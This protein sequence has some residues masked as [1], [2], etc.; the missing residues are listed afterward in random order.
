MKIL[1]HP[2]LHK[3]GTTSIQRFLRDAFGSEEPARIWYPM[4][5]ILSPGH[6]SLPK[7]LRTEETREAGLATLRNYVERAAAHGT[8]TLIISA[9]DISRVK[10]PVLAQMRECMAGHHLQLIVPLTSYKAR[11]VSQW[12]EG[13]KHHEKR[14]MHNVAVLKTSKYEPL[15]VSRLMAALGP[16]ES[17][18]IIGDKS[19]APE[20]LIRTFLQ[21]GDLQRHLKKAEADLNYSIEVNRS[22]GLIEIEVIRHVNICLRSLRKRGIELD[23]KYVKR[24]IAQVVTSKD[25]KQRVPKIKLQCPDSWI[26]E[27]RAQAAQ[28]R[29]D[30]EELNKSG[31][32]RIIGELDSLTADL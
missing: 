30:L 7:A 32:L 11:A 27:L 29:N 9:E 18:A 17:I 4:T 15:V 21:A 22:F 8:E 3:T 28:A 14:A 24:R 10:S 20:W 5:P 31:R 12:Q 16:D 13:V 26:E 25:W 19:Y 2:G 6:A 1:L 23:R